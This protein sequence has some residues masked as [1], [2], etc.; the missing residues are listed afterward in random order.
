[1]AYPSHSYALAHSR[2]MYIVRRACYF[3]V[4]FVD[5]KCQNRPA[6]PLRPIETRGQNSDTRT[7]IL[8][9]I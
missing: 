9:Q 3:G 6:H 5:P 7:F 8:E 2:I 1:M 4:C